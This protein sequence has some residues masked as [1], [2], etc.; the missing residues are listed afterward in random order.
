M[1]QLRLPFYEPTFPAPE[2]AV[3]TLLD[4]ALQVT[5]HALRDAHPLVGSALGEPER[6]PGEDIVFYAAMLI[7]GRCVELRELVGLYDTLIDRLRS[8]NDDDINF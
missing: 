4:A 6:E 8:S 1:R 7:V 5:E 2:R 3:L